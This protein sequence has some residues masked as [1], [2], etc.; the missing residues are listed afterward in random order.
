MEYA[1]TRPVKIQII[2]APEG[3][4]ATGVKESAPPVALLR[5]HV[6]IRGRSSGGR[7]Q[8]TNINIV[9]A[10]ISEN[11]FSERVFPHE[12]CAI[13]REG[14][15]RFSEVHQHIV[16]SAASALRLCADVAQ[17]FRLGIDIYQFD[18]IDNPVAPG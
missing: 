16:R 9:I 12:T 15:S 7:A 18:L 6:C 13:K 4:C 14:S 10:A 8:M 1:R 3:I 2:A 5:H 11:L 17:L